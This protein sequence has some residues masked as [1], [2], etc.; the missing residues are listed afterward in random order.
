MDALAHGVVKGRGGSGARLALRGDGGDEGDDVVLQVGAPPLAQHLGRHHADEDGPALVPDARNRIAVAG[1][2][3]KQVAE[4]GILHRAPR[5][6]ARV[7]VVLAV[8]VEHDPAG[9]PVVVKAP[10]HHRH[11]VELVKEIAVRQNVARTPRLSRPTRTRPR[12][13]LDFPARASRALFVRASRAL[14]VRASRASRALL[15]ARAPFPLQLLSR[16]RLAQLLRAP[17]AGHGPGARVEALG[18]K[19][20]RGR[21][22]LRGAPPRVEAAAVDLHHGHHRPVGHD[23]RLQPAHLLGHGPRLV[24]AQLPVDGSHGLG[25]HEAADGLGGYALH[26][27]LAGIPVVEAHPGDPL[28]EMQRDDALRVQVAVEGRL[29]G[30]AVA[31]VVAV[32]RDALPPAAVVAL[33]PRAADEAAPVEA[34][35]RAGRGREQ[36]V[37]DFC[38]CRRPRSRPRTHD[39][40]EATRGPPIRLREL[41]AERRSSN[42]R[43][44]SCLGSCPPPFLAQQLPPHPRRIHHRQV[45]LDP[46]ADFGAG[47]GRDEDAAGAI[48]LVLD[49]VGVVGEAI[50]EARVKHRREDHE[51]LLRRSGP[52]Q[53]QAALRR[54]SGYPPQV[55]PHRRRESRVREN[56]HRP[57]RHGE[58]RLAEILGAKRRRALQVVPAQR[59]HPLQVVPAQRHHPCHGSPTFTRIRRRN[60]GEE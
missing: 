30:V 9:R 31:V 5:G 26:D 55:V 54:M 52:P 40:G 3:A 18:G 20:L 44:G 1:N 37:G 10:A 53:R 42:F 13:F 46:A 33:A 22:F 34:G 11:L 38:R 27:Q 19:F 43:L 47:R 7:V 28:D 14:F 41:R 17:P 49:A 39:L 51:R 36:R 48:L 15:P 12:T 60:P 59:H 29:G 23:G 58:E 25:E 35:Q 8:G 57:G 45:A 6:H 24:L 4:P 56:P 2:R 32:I 50:V 16:F 21:G